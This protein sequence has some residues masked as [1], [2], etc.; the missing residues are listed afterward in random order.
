MI[1]VVFEVVPA[2][3]YKTTYLNIAADLRPMLDQ[4]DGFISIERFVSLTD[5]SKILSLSFWRDET[6]VEQWRNTSGHRDAQHLGRSG[7]FA[8]YRLRIAEV[9]RDYG[10]NERAEAPRDSRAI[11]DHRAT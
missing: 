1:A 8:D 9:V 11:H 2:P 10:L 3:E 4:I 6:A 5:P 7:V